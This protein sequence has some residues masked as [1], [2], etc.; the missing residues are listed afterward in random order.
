MNA[1]ILYKKKPHP[2]KLFSLALL[3]ILLVNFFVWINVP[4]G[5]NLVYI[6]AKKDSLAYDSIKVT[7]TVY[8]AVEEQCDDTPLITAD[9]Y[10]IN[11][12]KPERVIGASRDI[13]AM[14]GYGNKLY[15]KIP[16]AP[17]LDGEYTL[18]DTDNGKLTRHIDILIFN[19]NVCRIEG[20]WTGYILTPK[21]RR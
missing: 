18:H 4:F 6:H 9:G 15:L 7:V 17:Y 10:N 20:K 12:N 13:V 3:V 5:E 2:G 1:F 8:H 21:V 19:P 11:V 14:T 16:D